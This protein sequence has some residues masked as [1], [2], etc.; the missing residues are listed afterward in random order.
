M[1]IQ[2]DQSIFFPASCPR[3][4]TLGNKRRKRPDE[5]GVYLGT[6]LG[7]T[8]NSLSRCLRVVPRWRTD[9]CSHP[10]GLTEKGITQ[11]SRGRGQGR[12]VLARSSC[13][14]DARRSQAAG[15]HFEAWP[16]QNDDSACLPGM[17][18]TGKPDSMHTSLLYSAVFCYYEHRS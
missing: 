8:D 1:S 9:L 11:K 6:S 2:Q 3:F 16:L 4:A 18:P 15:P 12:N 14:L 13:Q 7:H 10:P 5:L 17:G